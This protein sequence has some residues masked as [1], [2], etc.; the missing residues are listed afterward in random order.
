MRKKKNENTDFKASRREGKNRENNVGHPQNT[1]HFKWQ[2]L[3]HWADEGGW[4]E[5]WNNESRYAWNIQSMK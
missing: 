4:G 5:W 3:L 2:P 1:G